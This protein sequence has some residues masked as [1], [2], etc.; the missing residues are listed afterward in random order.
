LFQF[1]KNLKEKKNK[2]RKN[3]F[4]NNFLIEEP[5]LTRPAD[6]PYEFQQSMRARPFN[7]RTP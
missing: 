3:N 5:T 4:G 6:G 1:K 2:F 7:A